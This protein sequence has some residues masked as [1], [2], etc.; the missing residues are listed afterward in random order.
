MYPAFLSALQDG[1]LYMIYGYV[2]R[3][4]IPEMGRMLGR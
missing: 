3:S 4:C 1:F 2:W